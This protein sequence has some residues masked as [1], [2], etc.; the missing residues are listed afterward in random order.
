MRP[1]SHGTPGSQEKDEVCNDDCVYYSALQIGSL[2]LTN[3]TDINYK[4]LQSI[5]SRVC[6]ELGDDRRKK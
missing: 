1:K 2:G 3:N 6:I 4:K 5:V